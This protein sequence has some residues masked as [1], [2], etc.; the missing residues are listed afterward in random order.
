[1]IKTK[2][3]GKISQPFLDRMDL[4]V[5][6]EPLSYEELKEN[7]GESTSAQ[8]RRAVQKAQKLQQERYQGQKI[9]FNSE[10]SVKEVQEYCHLTRE[11]EQLL[12]QAF[13]QLKLSARAYHGIIKTARTIADLEGAELI[14]SAHISEAVCLRSADKKIWRL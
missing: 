9:R 12:A 11:A 5:H 7:R 14:G 6:V 2:S 4:C 10:L 3:Q 13:A 8:M 1:M